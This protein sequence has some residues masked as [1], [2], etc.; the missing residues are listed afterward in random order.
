[1]VKR[2]A[3]SRADKDLQPDTLPLLYKTLVPLTPD[4][5]KGLY[6]AAKRNYA[7]AGMANALPLT[8]DEFAPAMR[9]Y[10]IVLAGGAVPTPVALVGYAAGSN[11]CVDADGAWLDNHYIP[12]YVRRYPFA[13]VRESAT[14]ERNI[15]CADL[16]SVLFES[17]GEDD[18]ALFNEAGETGSVINSVIE[19]C[20]KYDQAVE[21]TRLAMQE[22]ADLDLIQSSTVTITR[23]GKN[24]K[25]D[26]FQIISEEKL[27]ALP[28]DVLAGL[29]RRG[30]LTIYAA[31]HLSLTN[32]SSFG[33][34]T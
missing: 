28:D 25:V 1:M 5:H 19:F 34:D 7:Y 32:F 4:R 15:L 2:R 17:K 11:Q 31:H 29:A 23:G 9:N 6:F 24:Y 27:R 33:A 12:A 13:L 16:S 30:V 26:G 14:V 18:R 10:P 8:L 21:R 3:V 20:T 22:A